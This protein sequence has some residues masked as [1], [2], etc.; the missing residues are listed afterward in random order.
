MSRRTFGWDLPPGVTD[1]MI[2]EA[3]GGD[4]DSRSHH[5]YDLGYNDGWRHGYESALRDAELEIASLV[6]ISDRATID[7]A[8]SII[9]E[10]A[11]ATP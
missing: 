6:S 4:D 2:D 3:A 8:I 7:T 10:L 1:R 5:D 9:R 11:K